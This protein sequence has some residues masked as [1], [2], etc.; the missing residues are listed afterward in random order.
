[1][2]AVLV[3]WLLQTTFGL[4]LDPLLRQ[5]VPCT[6]AGD[7]AYVDT[8]SCAMRWLLAIRDHVVCAVLVAGFRGEILYHGSSL[9]PLF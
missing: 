8:I 4:P 1:M 2:G 9:F 7:P 6:F 3:F 5:G